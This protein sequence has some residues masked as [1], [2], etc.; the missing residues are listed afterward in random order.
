MVVCSWLYASTSIISGSQSAFPALKI[1]RIKD[2]RL[3]ENILVKS[4]KINNITRRVLNQGRFHVYYNQSD[5]KRSNRQPIKG[6]TSIFHYKGIQNH[7]RRFQRTPLVMCF[8]KPVSRIES[9][10]KA[11]KL[12]RRCNMAGHRRKH[13]LGATC[14][15]VVREDRDRIIYAGRGAGEPVVGCR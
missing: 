2:D 14:I 8:Y 4:K 10:G 15:V 12:T 1:R 6:D 7:P 5:D 11:E 3:A 9:Y 13:L